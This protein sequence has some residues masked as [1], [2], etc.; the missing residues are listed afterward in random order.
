MIF[1]NYF[2]IRF[3]FIFVANKEHG[4]KTAEHKNERRH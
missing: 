3:L 2:D 1:V 4:K